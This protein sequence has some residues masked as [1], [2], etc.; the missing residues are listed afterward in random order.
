[1]KLRR[2]VLAFALFGLLPAGRAEA[3]ERNPGV[4]SDA[5]LRKLLPSA[6]NERLGGNVGLDGD[7]PCAQG[8]RRQ[9]CL[10]S[11]HTQPDATAIDVE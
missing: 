10:H 7:Q 6:V 2:W 1:M 3:H 4:S 11:R 8:R 5:A 9:D